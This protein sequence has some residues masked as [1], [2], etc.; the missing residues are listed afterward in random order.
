MSKQRARDT[1]PEKELRSLLHARGLRYR[2]DYSP[3][4][5]SRRRADVVFTRA[6]VAV[7]VHGCFWHSCP[8]HSTKPKANA[9]WWKE[10]LERNV[11]RDHETRQALAD[12]E[13]TV[14]E[15]WEHEDPQ[16]AADVVEHIV[17]AAGRQEM[18][19]T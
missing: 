1:K 16:T 19:Q 6:R 17:R 15:F 18:P 8:V 5:Q 13:W 3:I 2:V 11:E 7:L 12:Q 10:K 9:Q 4:P 14:L